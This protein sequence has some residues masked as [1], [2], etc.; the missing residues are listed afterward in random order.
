MPWGAI[1]RRRSACRLD[2]DW[3]TLAVGVV[4]STWWV[5]GLAGGFHVDLG[6]EQ[7]PLALSSMMEP[8][9][10]PPLAPPLFKLKG[11]LLQG[12]LRK[13]CGSLGEAWPDTRPAH[14]RAW[15]ELREALEQ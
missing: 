15:R 6:F 11:L 3:M 4:G 14:G 2:W 9:P 10:P 8:A 7:H 5:G 12:R 13:P 1:C